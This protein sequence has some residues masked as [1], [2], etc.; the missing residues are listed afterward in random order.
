VPDERPPPV[1][2]PAG[3]RSAGGVYLPAV[4]P[5]TPGTPPPEPTGSEPGER[6]PGE[7]GDERYGPLRITR[8]HK[9]DGRE[10]IF[11]SDIRD[12]RP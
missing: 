5:S 4:A 6:T 11:F 2:R 7:H 3:A 1:V 12:E 8:T 10:L 9:D